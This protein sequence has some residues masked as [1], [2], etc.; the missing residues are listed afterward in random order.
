MPHGSDESDL[1]F[2][3]GMFGRHNQDHALG[4]NVLGFRVEVGALT[5]YPFATNGSS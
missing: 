4:S 3:V 5:S 1:G 2:G